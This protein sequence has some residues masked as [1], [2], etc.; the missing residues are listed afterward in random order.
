MV[1]NRFRWD[2]IG[3]STDEKPTPANSEKVVDGST[4][5][6][7]DTS[8]LYVFCKD[9]WYEKTAT[10]G[11]GTT[12]FNELDNRPKYNGTVMSGETDIPLAPSIVQTTGNST[13]DVMSQNATTSM[14]YADP[15]N[16]RK[17]CIGANASARSTDSTAIGMFTGTGVA[18]E[19]SVAIGRYAQATGDRSL[20]IGQGQYQQSGVGTKPYAPTTGS[21]AIGSTAGIQDNK[22]ESIAIGDRA[23]ARS[24]YSVALG[25][26]AET[27]RDGEVNV[28]TT[29]YYSNWGFNQ[30]KYRVIGGVHDG[31]EAHDAVTVEQVNSMID[32]INTALNTS[33]PHIGA[34]A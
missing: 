1:N 14:V 21:I 31:Q 19:G 10:G 22:Q 28:G 24:S 9:T 26:G 23:A 3:L 11:G 5:Y 34:N 13:T 15:V 6:C 27:T 4:Y 8:K 18:G 17:I 12:D 30:T 29:D 16:K 32:A 33:I 20:A 7:S 2:F 25:P